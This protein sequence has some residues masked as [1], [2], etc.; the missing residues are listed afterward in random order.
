MEEYWVDVT[1]SRAQLKQDSLSR[2]YGE[3]K[4]QKAKVSDLYRM[5]CVK[6]RL[7]NRKAR[8]FFIR[9]YILLVFLRV[10][11][12]DLKINDYSN[13]KRRLME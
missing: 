10:G 7:W 3:E 5:V 1:G 8:A 13:P 11:G 4:N 2:V 12:D 6:R 9:I